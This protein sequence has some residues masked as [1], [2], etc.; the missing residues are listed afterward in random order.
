MKDSCCLFEKPRGEAGGGDTCYS[1]PKLFRFTGSCAGP[2]LGSE[3]F[4]TPNFIAEQN[5][6]LPFPP[7]PSASTH[8][9][10]LHPP[11]SVGEIIT[12]DA[13]NRGRKREG[14]LP[15]RPR[16][17]CLARCASAFTPLFSSAAQGPPGA[18]E[19]SQHPSVSPTHAHH[20]Q[21]TA[22]V[23]H[24]NQHL[25][26]VVS[27]SPLLKANTG[28]EN[29]SRLSCHSRRETETDTTHVNFKNSL[30]WMSLSLSLICAP[31]VM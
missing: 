30:R 20:L 1:T 25:F 24:R 21:R 4:L 11:R 17:C 23:S 26:L 19:R 28:E 2:F 29:Q 31:A 8:L 9:F 14:G 13:G 7:S 12:A 15:V 18:R 3:T 16:P 6:P 10:A 27:V 22:P 5:A